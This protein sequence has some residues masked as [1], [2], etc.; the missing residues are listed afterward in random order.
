MLIIIVLIQVTKVKGELRTTLIH[1]LNV[2]FQIF[3][4]GIK[5]V[6][7]DKLICFFNMLNFLIEMIVRF[8]VKH[9]FNSF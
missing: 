2:N 7:F 5:S 6:F 4:H 1:S 8:S 9:H 3:N